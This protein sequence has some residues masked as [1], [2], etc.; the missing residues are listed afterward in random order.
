MVVEGIL[1]VEM[2]GPRAESVVMMCR[3]HRASVHI[4]FSRPM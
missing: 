2:I 4:G 1:I 3:G